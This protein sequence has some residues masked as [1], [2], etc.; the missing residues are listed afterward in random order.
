MGA[1]Y[2][3]ILFRGIVLGFSL[4]TEEIRPGTCSVSTVELRG[5]VGKDVDGSNVPDWP[6]LSMLIVWPYSCGSCKCVRD[7]FAPPH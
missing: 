3:Q 6:K 1:R 4:Y 5:V 7:S 2:E